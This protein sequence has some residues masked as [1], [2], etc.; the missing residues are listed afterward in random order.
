MFEYISENREWIF[1]G[2]GVTALVILGGCLYKLL[3]RKEKPQPDN[4][5][6]ID[7]TP[8]PSIV[9]FYNLVP[10]FVLK[11]RFLEPR[12][13]SLIKMD[14]RPR[15]E[16]IR[17]NCGELPDCQIWLQVIN[18][19]PFD[20]DIENIKGDLNY[21]GCKINVETKEHIDIPKHSSNN[22]VLLEGTLTGEQANHC[23]KDNGVSYTSLT[24]R[25]R[26]RTSFGIFKK[27]SDDLQSLHVHIMN[28]R[29]AQI[30]TEIANGKLDALAEKA[31]ADHK[32][33]KSKKL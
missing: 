8:T 16:P 19:S 24:L 32:A 10:N 11:H 33:G 22:C 9:S 4:I 7:F 13:N 5:F 12:I 28:K 2:A 23:S 26:I 25:S 15:G 30:E 27:Q 20:L 31:I 1:S 14:V 18:H 29:D 6:G 21:N 17:L 3:K